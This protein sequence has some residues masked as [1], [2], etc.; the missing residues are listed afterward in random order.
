MQY[1]INIVLMQRVTIAHAVAFATTF[2]HTHTDTAVGTT[3]IVT[4][5]KTIFGDHV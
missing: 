3:F 1:Y 4:V 5:S 2:A